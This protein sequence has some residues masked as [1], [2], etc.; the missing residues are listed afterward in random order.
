[1]TRKFQ[2]PNK[3]T[4]YIKSQLDWKKYWKKY[5]LQILSQVNKKNIKPWAESM[6]ESIKYTLWE[7]NGKNTSSVIKKNTTK[8]QGTIF[9]ILKCLTHFFSD[10]TLLVLSRCSGISAFRYWYLAF[11]TVKL[12]SKSIVIFY[13]DKVKIILIIFFDTGPVILL[14]DYFFFKWELH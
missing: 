4:K 10:Y 9:N 12:F 13:K 1:M 2:I 6:W 14:R 3:A 7:P 8:P 5:D 11:K